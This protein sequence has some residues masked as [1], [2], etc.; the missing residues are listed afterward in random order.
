MTSRPNPVRVTHLTL[1]EGDHPDQV[2]IAMPARHLAVI[3]HVLGQ[4]A[5][6]PSEAVEVYDCGRILFERY[7]GDVG[8]EYAVK[9]ER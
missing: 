8:V 5:G 4:V 2:T 9:A 3:T 7:Y 1:A 6:A